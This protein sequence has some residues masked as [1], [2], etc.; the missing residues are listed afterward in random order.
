MPDI[1]ASIPCLGTVS[2]RLCYSV[3]THE[4]MQPNRSNQTVGSSRY[5]S[6]Y[7]GRT[8]ISKECMSEYSSTFRNWSASRHGQITARQKHASINEL[9]RRF[10]I[11]SHQVNR[12][13][14]CYMRARGR[15]KLRTVIF[16]AK[17]ACHCTM[18]NVVLWWT[19]I[20][21]HCLFIKHFQVGHNSRIIH[22][23][24]LS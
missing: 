24:C 22:E 20:E 14:T 7:V 9:M 18:C 23:I 11:R 8:T 2:N 4:C 19:L 17:I 12:F 10:G 3:N 6:W 5:V 1:F 15:M 16:T 21:T 13:A